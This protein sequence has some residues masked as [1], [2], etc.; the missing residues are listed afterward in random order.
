MINRIVSI[1][2]C[3]KINKLKSESASKN[4]NS[5][6]SLPTIDQPGDG[7]LLM[8]GETSNLETKEPEHAR[9]FCF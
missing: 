8:I 1:S 6:I 5:F 4:P 2:C 3:C 9:F 7:K